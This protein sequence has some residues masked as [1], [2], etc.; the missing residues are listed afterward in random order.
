MNI[1]GI[2]PALVTPF[3]EDESINYDAL[4]AL[5]ER[6][7]EK[8]AEGFYICG[9]T[10]ECFLMSPEERKSLAEF[11]TREVNGRVPIIAQVGNIGTGLAEDLARHAASCGVN[12][13]SSV[14]PFYFK[15]GVDELA[16]YYAAI[17]KA[18]GNL[19]LVIYSIPALSGVSITCKDIGKIIEVSGAEGL[20][21][22]SYDLF[23]LERIRR[24]NPDLTIF[25]GH[26]EVYANAMPIGIDGAIGSTFNLMP[27]KYKAIR[28]AYEKNDMKTVSLLQSKVNVLI[29]ALIQAG[30]NPGIKYLLSKRGIPCGNCRRPFA[31]LS[32]EKK[33]LLDSIEAD[34]FDC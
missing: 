8:G 4:S 32:D 7:I 6:S 10:A 12:A 31:P 1:K 17:R 16:N 25:N 28:E 5:I 30:V 24:A 22:T 13:I 21:Y 2:I 19:P 18:S 23:E 15:F 20:K 29:D 9:S 26:D 14:P 3:K 27:W 34:V 11:I 33:A